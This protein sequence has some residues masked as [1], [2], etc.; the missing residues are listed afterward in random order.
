LRPGPAVHVISICVAPDRRNQGIGESL[1]GSA[2]H[3]GR[4]NG[5]TA[6]FLEVR[7]ENQS[8]RGFYFQRGFKAVE[9]LADFYGE[10]LDGV[11]MQ[12]RLQPLPGFRETIGFLARRLNDVPRLGVVLG[13]GLGWLADR[14]GKGAAIPYSSIPG[15]SGDAVAGHSLELRTSS[16]G[17]IAFLMGRRH[18]YQGYTGD[19]ITLLPGALAALGVGSWLLTSSAGGLDPT[20]EVGDAMVFADHINYSGCV[21]H[22]PDCPIGHNIYSPSLSRLAQGVMP[23]VHRG[24]FACVSGPAY[25]TECEVEMLRGSGASA[26]SMSTAQEAMVLRALGCRVLAVALITNAVKG[27]DTVNHEEVL[28]AQQL[29]SQKQGEALACLIRGLSN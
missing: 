20:Y 6:A 10:G 27:G 17:S 14:F 8:A 2:V 24:I 22:Q 23:G 13:S 21:P 11:F 18:H 4:V 25:E 19:G 29:I 16:D 7:E 26:V 1:L 9:R 3:W 28:S 15:M 5:A 12:R